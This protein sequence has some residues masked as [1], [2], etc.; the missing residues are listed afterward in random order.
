MFRIIKK[1]TSSN[2]LFVN[3]LNAAERQISCAIRLYFVQE[4]SL[5][6]HTVANA[7]Y[8]IFSDL[9]AKRG[10]PEASW[11]VIYGFL[12][13]AHKYAHK[14]VDDEWVEEKF[15]S[16]SGLIRE[17]AKQFEIHSDLLPDD[18]SIQGSDSRFRSS[19]MELRQSA[20]FLKHADRGVAGGTQISGV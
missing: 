20:N 10:K 15:E 14:E 16:V 8:G 11:P 3:K 17:L 9:L 12:V 18:C 2:R 1:S 4:D 5:S 7:A 19:W 6:T 13:A